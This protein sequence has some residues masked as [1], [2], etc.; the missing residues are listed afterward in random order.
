M[1][2]IVSLY[3]VSDFFH[4]V[5]QPAQLI[6]VRMIAKI[7]AKSIS[8]ISLGLFLCSLLIKS[9]NFYKILQIV[10]RI[11]N[12]HAVGIAILNEATSISQNWL[13]SRLF[14]YIFHQ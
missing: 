6:A 5:G 8:D 12:P 2:I 1:K 13:V 3:S 7:R 11:F 4:K 10:F 14:T 9:G